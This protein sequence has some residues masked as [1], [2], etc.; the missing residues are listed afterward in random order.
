M[1]GC[2]KETVR[3]GGRFSDGCNDRKEFVNDTFLFLKVKW[4]KSN[5]KMWTN[6]RQKKMILGLN[7][8]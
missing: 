8:M 3:A 2:R 4:L 7:Q 6:L 1:Y 5:P